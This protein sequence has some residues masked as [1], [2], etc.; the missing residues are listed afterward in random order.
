MNF[1]AQAQDFDTQPGVRSTAQPKSQD[2]VDTIPVVDIN[3]SCKRRPLGMDQQGRYPDRANDL[4]VGWGA[5][6][7]LLLA[8][9]LVGACAALV[10]MLKDFS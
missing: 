5:L 6:L 8:L 1:F 9:A 7:P 3:L 10:L 2:F 4:Q